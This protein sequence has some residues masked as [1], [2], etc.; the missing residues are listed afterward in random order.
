MTKPT[1]TDPAAERVAIDGGATCPRCSAQAVPSVM[2]AIRNGL[3][4]RI[5]MIGA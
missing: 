3:P 1:T 2:S 4:P 5:G